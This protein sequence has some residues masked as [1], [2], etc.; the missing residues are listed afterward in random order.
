MAR[1]RRRHMG[2]VVLGSVKVCK[3]KGRKLVCKSEKM[4]GLGRKP[5]RRRHMAGSVILGAACRTAKGKFTKC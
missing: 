3:M 5:R 1:R 4:A 2:S